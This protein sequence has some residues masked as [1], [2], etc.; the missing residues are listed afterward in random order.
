[1]NSALGIFNQT[2]DQV[3]IRTSTDRHAGRKTE[4]EKQERKKESQ[5]RETERHTDRQTDRGHAPVSV[6][7][8]ASA[9]LKYS[10]P[11]FHS[12]I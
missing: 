5:R 3:Q 1:M 8:C 11:E 2:N 10:F 9:C 4:T 7:M 6:L 12:N